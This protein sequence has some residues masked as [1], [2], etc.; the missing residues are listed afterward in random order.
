MI[1]R[2]LPVP[3]VGTFFV[4]RKPAQVDFP[5]KQVLPPVYSFAFSSAAVSP[6][7]NIFNWLAAALGITPHDAVIRFND[8]AFGMKKQVEAGD[9]IDW[10]GV[11]MIEKG[12]AGEVRFTPA[13]PLATERPV[14]AAK[15]LREKAEHTVRV[16]EDERTAAEME[17]MLS[18]TTEKRS[19]WWA[20]AL[21][22]GLLSLVFT[23]WYLSEHGVDTSAVSL[24]KKMVPGEPQPSYKILP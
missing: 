15:V 7:K 3:G 14:P 19:Y 4:E 5:N 2:N 13:V 9:L 11:G 20:Y 17:T 23:G 12:L 18:K 24:G 21:V 10:K 6:Q 1:Y 22:I 16:G 8:F